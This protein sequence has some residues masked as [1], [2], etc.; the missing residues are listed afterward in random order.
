MGVVPELFVF[1]GI[2][3]SFGRY[4]LVTGETALFGFRKH[5]PLGSWSPF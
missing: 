4:A 3:G 5:V 2:D 1:L